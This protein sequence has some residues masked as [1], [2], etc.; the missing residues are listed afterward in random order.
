MLK[1]RYQ[2]TPTILNHLT[3][4]SVAREVILNAPLVPKWELDL[5]REALIRSAH[6]STSIEGNNLS[7]GEVS[8]L[9][10]GRE[11][12]TFGRDKQEVLNYLHALKY[13]D[14]LVLVGKIDNKSILKLHK[15]ITTKTLDNPDYCGK[16]RHGNQYVIVGNRFTGEITYRPP[17]TKEVPELM[18]DLID[19]INE[20][21]FGKLNPILAAGI[22]HYEFVRIHPFIDGNGRTARI[23]ATY[24][25]LKS[26]FD[27]KRFFTLDD[28]Y[29][30]DRPSYY[31]ALK[32]V[33]PTK[34]E[35]TEWLEYFCKG[36][37]V[38]LEAV[39]KKI[40]LLT[41]GRTRDINLNQVALGDRHVKVIEYVR[42]NAQI[43]NKKARELLNISNKTAYLLLTTFC[44]HDVLVKRGNGR[45]VFYILK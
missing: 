5:R 10:A 32:T 38:S 27:T 34:R 26:G 2:I 44:N 45:N 28:F 12:T 42:K 40:M 9:E 14:R 22:V 17:A 13:L 25:L 35:L 21:D 19:F 16:Y 41:G 4:I 1:P 11:V 43:T 8:D 29:N 33:D 6:A 23:L 39:R 37:N 36:V 15:M 20:L 31:G 24:I 30:S 18:D 7:Y 3:N